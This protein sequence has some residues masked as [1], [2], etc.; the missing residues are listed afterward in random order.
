MIALNVTVAV[1]LELPGIP[2]ILE[3]SKF[4]QEKVPLSRA[5]LLLVMP[6]G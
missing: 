1:A 3:A 4:A 2:R 6:H 5:R